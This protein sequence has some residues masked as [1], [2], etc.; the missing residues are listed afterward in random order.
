MGL[1]RLAAAVLGAGAASLNTTL[2]NSWIDYFESGDMSG[3]VSQKR[4]NRIVGPRSKNKN[5]DENIISS[6]SIID[7][8]ENQCMILVEDGAI[9]DFCAEPGRYQF[10]ASQA[11]SALAGSNSGFA[12]LAHSVV[13]QFKA[14]GQRVHTQRVYFIN[15]GEIQGFKWGSGNITFDHWENDWTTNKPIWHIATTLMGNGVYSIQVTDPGKFFSVI[16]AQAT[17]SNGSGLVRR[18]DIEPQIKSEAIAAI[19]QGFSTK[20]GMK[21][22]ASLSS[23]SLSTCLTLMRN[24]RLRSRSSRRPEATQI[25]PC[26]ALTWASARHRL[27]RQRLPIQPARSQASPLWA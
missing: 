4:A 15:L 21:H 22:A 2:G 12:A 25:R 27:L 17:G 19:R 11:P 3:G 6:G 26:S 24:Q 10:D 20:S 13:E 1:I 8:Q 14:G 16:G 9:V 18:E 7:V 5:S 23:R